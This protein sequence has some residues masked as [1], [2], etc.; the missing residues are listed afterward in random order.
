M[1]KQKENEMEDA[2]EITQKQ[3][4][5]LKSRLSARGGEPLF[6]PGTET[7]CPTCGGVMVTTNNVEEAVAT[8][9]LVMFITRLPGAKCVSCGRTLIDGAAA[10]TLESRFSSGMLAD[11]ET[12]VTRAS[13]KTL[14][15]YFKQDLVRVLGLTG[16]EQLFWKVVDRDRVL[17]EVSRYRSREGATSRRRGAGRKVPQHRKAAGPSPNRSDSVVTA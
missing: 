13:G 6:P 17:V 15:T 12:T 1:K 3:I 10:A 16:K 5:E 8:P 9:G 7:V 4:D 11:Y 2:P 14:G